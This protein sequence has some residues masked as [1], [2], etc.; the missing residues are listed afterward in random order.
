MELTFILSILSGSLFAISEFMSLNKKIKS[1]GI[2]QSF[3]NI[4][5]ESSGAG[6]FGQE[7]SGGGGNFGQEPSNLSQESSDDVVLRLRNDSDY[8][9]IKLI[10]E[11]KTPQS[12]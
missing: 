4:F 7:S 12:H 6:N 1:N 9:S 10:L 11:K 3:I 5:K 8:R 2:I